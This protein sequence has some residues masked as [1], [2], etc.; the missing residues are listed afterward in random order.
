MGN[1]NVLASS[2]VVVPKVTLGNDNS[3]SAGEVLFDDIEDR[4]LVK[5]NSILDKP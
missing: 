2:A 5:A 1:N 4:K 3:I